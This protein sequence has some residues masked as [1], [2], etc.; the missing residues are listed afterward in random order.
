MRPP[1]SHACRETWKLE[2]AG[3]MC[4]PPVDDMAA[5][6]FAFLAKLAKENGVAGLS[7]GM[8]AD[9]EAAVNLGAT[10]VRVGSAIFGHRVMTDESTMPSSSVSAAW[11]RR[12]C[13][14]WR[15]GASACSGIEQFDLGHELGSSGAGIRIYRFAQFLDPAYVPLMRHAF[16][17]WARLERDAGEQLLFRTGGLD[18][19][20][21][22]R[23]DRRRLQARVRAA[24]AAARG[25]DGAGG[26]AAVSGVVA[27]G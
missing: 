7:M 8:S 6:H 17:H 1:S 23:G 13:V 25:D 2:I 12:R 27:A 16:H 5:V 4:I 24:R 18:I 10:H 21:G 3:L 14:R 15:G 22:G 11:A 20:P 9:Y 26:D 19:G